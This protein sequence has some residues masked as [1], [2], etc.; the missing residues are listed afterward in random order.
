M[1][2]GFN[3]WVIAVTVGDYCY[4]DQNYQKTTATVS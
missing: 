3:C 2:T 4:W 1:Q